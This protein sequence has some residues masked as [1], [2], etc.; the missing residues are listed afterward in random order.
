[1]LSIYSTKHT[2]KSIHCTMYLANAILSAMGIS[3]E[4][5][6][7]SEGK[8]CSRCGK[9]SLRLPG[10]LCP[11]CFL[12]KSDKEEKKIERRFREAELRSVFKGRRSLV[13]RPI[14]CPRKNEQ[15]T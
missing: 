12:R 3:K 4:E 7:Q 5:F 13:K 6:D 9:L 1:M 14:A 8:P 15:Q 11:R 2:S 10:G